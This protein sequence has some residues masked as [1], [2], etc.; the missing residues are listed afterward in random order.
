MSQMD[1]KSARYKYVP[2]NTTLGFYALT[3]AAKV[4]FDSLKSFYASNVLPIR[5]IFPRLHFEADSHEATLMQ[6]LIKV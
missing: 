1:S 4:K 3:P 2:S 5:L 6:P